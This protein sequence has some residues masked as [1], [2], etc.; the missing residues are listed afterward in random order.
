MEVYCKEVRKLED[1]FHGIELIHIA[2]RYN[3]AADE[4]A[5]IA[6]TRGTVLPNAFSRDMHG[7]CV[8]LGM[9]DSAE[10]SAPEPTDTIEALLTAAEAMA[11]EQTSQ[12]LGR[13][14]DWRTPFLDYLIQLNC[15]KTELR[16][17]VSLD[18]P[19]RT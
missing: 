17:T 6:S 4:L 14:F 11:V 2:R 19:N 16:S 13:P 12:H 10:T 8:D 5:K 15:Q 9:G 7:P 18:G 1:N 3:E